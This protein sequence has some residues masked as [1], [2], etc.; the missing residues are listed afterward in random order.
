[1]L[2]RDFTILVQNIV[3]QACKLRDKYVSEPA[4]VN[5][6]CIFSQS[7]EEYE[8]F[9]AFAREIGSVVHETNMGPVFQ[10]APIKTVAGNL[11]VLKIRKPDPTRPERGDTDFT[12]PDYEAFKQAKLGEPGFKIIQKPE[13]EMIELADPEFKVLVYFSNPP[14]AEVLHLA[15]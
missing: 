5:Y 7:Q 2:Q 1:M 13:M 9:L 15:L 4:P 12:L 6:A 11:Q 14:L 8:T 10:I 3:T